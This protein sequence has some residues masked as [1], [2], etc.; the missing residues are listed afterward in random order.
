MFSGERKHIR[1]ADKRSG[2]LPGF[3]RMLLRE[4]LGKIVSGLFL[5]LGYFWAVF[6]RDSQAWHDKIAGTV[7]LKKA[8][9]PQPL[10]T[11]AGAGFS[12]TSA[13]K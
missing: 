12:S 8:A 5:G 11:A 2:G 4:T 13:A 10:A 1:A 3:G 9:A 6:D 7:V